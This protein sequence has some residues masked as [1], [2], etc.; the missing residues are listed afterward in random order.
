MLEKLAFE[1]LAPSRWPPTG[2]IRDKY[3][4]KLVYYYRDFI[5]KSTRTISS[6][7]SSPYSVRSVSEGFVLAARRPGRYAAARAISKSDAMDEITVA[8]SSWRIP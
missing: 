8:G 5:A 3:L 4:V 1:T 6:K 2:W 7:V